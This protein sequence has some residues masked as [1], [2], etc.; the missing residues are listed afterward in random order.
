MKISELPQA[1][2]ITGAEILP[3]VQNGETK[4]VS[5]DDL[6]GTVPNGLTVENGKMFLLSNGEKVDE[7][8]Q[9]PIVTIDKVLLID[10]ENPVQNKAVKNEL[11]KKL[12][13][14]DGS[15]KQENIADGSVTESKLSEDV[16]DKLNKPQITVDSEL[17]AESENPVKNK[18]ISNSFANALKGTAS[19]KI[20]EI[21][22]ISPITHALKV[23][24]ES[25]TSLTG[26][27]VRR[28]GKNQ[29]N[30]SSVQKRGDTNAITLLDNGF[31]VEG[32]TYVTV[33]SIPVLPNTDYTLSY[34]TT[35]I[36]GEYNRVC[37]FAN[38]SLEVANRLKDITNGT[39]DTFN[40]G[41]AEVI[42]IA[43]YVN[44]PDSTSD[45]TVKFTDI[46]LE[47]GTQK[48]EYEPYVP[49][50]EVTPNDDGTI[51]GLTSAYPHTVI[52]GDGNVNL[53]CEYNKDLNRG[54]AEEIKNSKPMLITFNNADFDNSDTEHLPTNIS[55]SQNGSHILLTVTFD[56][57]RLNFTISD[58]SDY[59]IHNVLV[60]GEP[61]D[62]SM[63]DNYIKSM[64]LFSSDYGE[65]WIV[66]GGQYAYMHEY[67]FGTVDNANT[68]FAELSEMGL[69]GFQLLVNNYNKITAQEV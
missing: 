40:T 34:I 38:D 9:L 48:T 12:G 53:E 7:G 37:V 4:K 23:K 27:T 36:T 18:A 54:I 11:D 68:V 45:D 62:L 3:V 2:E 33:K 24:A 19:G 29:L 30:F 59:S 43:F 21:E 64:E 31:K 26:V 63:I 46:Q 65:G 1:A 10:S 32:R 50:Q 6:V 16:K 22:D 55:F 66:E 57:S 8:A 60:Q 52:V 51:D 49:V 20:L 67:N 42:L 15:V 44:S 47:L 28:Y 56:V 13:N 17:S 58:G 14:S 35:H 61:F 69:N 39:G 25:E 41:T 5:R